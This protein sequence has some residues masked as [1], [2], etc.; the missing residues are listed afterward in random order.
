MIHYSYRWVLA[1]LSDRGYGAHLCHVEIVDGRPTFFTPLHDVSKF[2]IARY[3][4]NAKD[5][6]KVEENG[7]MFIL[8]NQHKRLAQCRACGGLMFQIESIKGDTHTGCARLI[9]VRSGNAKQGDKPFR[10]GVLK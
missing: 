1:R 10:T 2:R 4:A 9:T 7:D 5:L 8:K 6:I 3:E